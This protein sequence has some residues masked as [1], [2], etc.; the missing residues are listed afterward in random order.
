MKKIIYVTGSRAEFGLMY[1]TLKSIDRNPHLDLNIIVTGVHL[2]KEHNSLKVVEQSGLKIS[3]IIHPNVDITKSG[4]NAAIF[5]GYL[6]EEL[7]KAFNEIHPDIILIEADRYEQLSVAI[8]ATHL[9]I[10]IVHVSGG[11]VSKSMDD[12]IRHAITKMAHIHLPGTEESAERIV[13]MGEEPW[14]VHMV[15]TPIFKDYGSKENVEKE[16]NLDLSQET[17]L[18]IQHPV[19]SQVNESEEQMR[20]TLEAVDSFNK[21]T[22]ILYPSGDQGSEEI[23]KVIKEYEKKENF[24]IFKN[25]KPAIFM[26]LLNNVSVMIGN[27]SAAIVEAPFFKL[28]AINVGMREGGRERAENIIDSPH[29][30]EKIKN[31]INLAL[32]TEFKKK[33]E[34]MENPYESEKVEE[35]IC[36]VLKKLKLGEDLINKK[37]TY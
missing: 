33:L 5:S 20:Q 12:A 35:N 10:P 17:F 37:M 23:I 24:H 21:Q 26:G 36:E 1:S 9:G 27:S 18:V 29:D 2:T 8:A 28:P 6:L 34:T 30:I 15:G 25:L 4:T 14:R 32:S 13:K 31:A 3:K 7:T 11:D 16:I 22:I 19:N